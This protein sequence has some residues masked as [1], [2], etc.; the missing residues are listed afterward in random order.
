MPFCAISGFLVYI[1]EQQVG[2][3][4]IVGKVGQF[5]WAATPPCCFS[6]Y[7]SQFSLLP[8]IH[9]ANSN[10]YP[11]LLFGSKSV[12]IITG[13][14]GQFPWAAAPPCCFILLCPVYRFELCQ[15]W[16]Y[17]NVIN[18]E[19]PCLQGRLVHHL[20]SKRFLF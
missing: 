20:S 3:I 16:W 17:A 1:P 15:S 13:K 4:I 18:F 7:Y 9:L 8:R 10:F 6:L 19:V 12:I 11:L 14:V 2:V 5:A